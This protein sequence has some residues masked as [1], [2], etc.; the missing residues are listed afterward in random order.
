[1]RRANDTIRRIY[2]QNVARLA[3]AIEKG[4]RNAEAAFRHIVD[5]MRKKYR[6]GA[7]DR[8]GRCYNLGT[9]GHDAETTEQVE[10]AVPAEG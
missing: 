6:L 10:G 9:G 4:D 8:Q 1:M 2:E 7:D 3:M 5:A